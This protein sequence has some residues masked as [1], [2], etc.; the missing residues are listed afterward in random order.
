MVG[1]SRVD[2]QTA[3]L[4]GIACIQCGQSGYHVTI[5][6]GEVDRVPIGAGS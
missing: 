6:T 4:S 1:L 2:V 3:L 5:Y